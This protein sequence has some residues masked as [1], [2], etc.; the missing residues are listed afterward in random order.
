[1]FNRIL[2][3]LAYALAVVALSLA[4]ASADELVFP[5]G[6][7]LGLVPPTGLKPVA[8]VRGNPNIH[9]FEDAANDAAIGMLELPPQVYADL[10]RATTADTLKKQGLTLEKREDLSLKDGT[11]VLFFG[12]QETEHANLRKWIL[13]A[14]MPDMTG[15]VTV[16]VPEAA[17]SPYPDESVHAALASVTRREKVPVEEQLG[18]LPYR[19]ADLA[20]F[21]VIRVVGGTLVVLTD[22]PKDSMEA[23]EQPHIVVTVGG[24][25]P[26]DTN[27][28][29]NFSR[30]LLIG[31]P[32]FK[33]VR[34]TNS[35]LLRLN[36]QQ[37]YELMADA[38]DAKTDAPVK[39]VQWVRFGGN[40]YVQIIAAAPK[41][42]WVQAFPRFRAVRDGIGPKEEP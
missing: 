29:A 28:R 11:A 33:D 30:N 16:E 4:P 1:M 38:K 36:G 12:K 39:L 9:G 20:G 32:G 3:R 35:D 34:L 7:H 42:G 19:L 6:S 27:S 2:L 14:S 8:A 15:L 25:G 22:G 5:P 18:M 41:D 26:E 23:V 24:G 37:T 31:I 40:G 13:L 17:G 21:R 10:A